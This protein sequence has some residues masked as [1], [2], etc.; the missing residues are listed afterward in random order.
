MVFECDRCHRD[1]IYDAD[2]KPRYIISEML[3]I[4]AGDIPTELCLCP[5]CL[6]EL[7][8]FMDYKE[9]YILAGVETN[10]SME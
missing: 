3:Y 9:V 7:V 6:E 4:S 1:Y 10:D 2:A 8:R 5:E